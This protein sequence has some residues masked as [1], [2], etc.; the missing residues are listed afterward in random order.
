MWVNR[1]EEQRER[2]KGNPKKIRWFLVR[3]GERNQAQARTGQIE[4]SKGE[5][6]N[7]ET[8]EVVIADGKGASCSIRKTE[9]WRGWCNQR[10]RK[11]SF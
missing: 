10:R 5:G 1:E 3:V 7:G 8:T 6:R 2:R 11:S 9:E 4:N